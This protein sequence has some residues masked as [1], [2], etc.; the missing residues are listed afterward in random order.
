MEATQTEK[1]YHLTFTTEGKETID[2]YITVRAINK[3]LAVAI[4]FEKLTSW[5]AK[6]KVTGITID[7][8]PSNPEATAVDYNKTPEVIV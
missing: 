4:G 7:E 1:V 5:R 6:D 3:P 8:D 2:H